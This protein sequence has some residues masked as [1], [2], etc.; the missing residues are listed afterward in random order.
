MKDALD[1]PEWVLG[2]NQA[3][4]NSTTIAHSSLSKCWNAI[5]YHH[6]HKA[7]AAGICHFEHIPSIQNPS[8][9][10]TKSLPWSKAHAF[11]KPFLFWKRDT[12]LTTTSHQRGVT[13]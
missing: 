8:D 11:I 6:C 9:A 7:V 4:I 1:G 3:I 10:L 13:D 2:D 12:N 5:S